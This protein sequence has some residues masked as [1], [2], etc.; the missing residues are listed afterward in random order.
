MMDA[1]DRHRRVYWQCRR[2]MLE[3]DELLQAYFDR[4]YAR[5]SAEE[6]GSFERLLAL[7]DQELF[8]L[9]LRGGRCADPTLSHVIEQIRRP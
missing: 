4:R 7:P 8:E 9:L 1:A 5:V 2:G 6:R 3:L